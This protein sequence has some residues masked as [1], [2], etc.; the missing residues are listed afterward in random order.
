MGDLHDI[1]DDAT[2]GDAAIREE[3]KQKFAEFR[4]AVAA[5]DLPAINQLAGDMRPICVDLGLTEHGTVL[6]QVKA[7]GVAA[8]GAD[9]VLALFDDRYIPPAISRIQDDPGKKGAEH[10]MGDQEDDKTGLYVKPI[11]PS[12]PL[13]QL[14]GRLNDQQ[15]AEIEGFIASKNALAIAKLAEYAKGD[16][17]FQEAKK[18]LRELL[19]G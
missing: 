18:Q 5:N 19:K 4:N 8:V 17:M 1:E 13:G 11:D 3:L 7:K 10:G 6:S 12:S 2:S 9:K 14:F 15:R 16:E